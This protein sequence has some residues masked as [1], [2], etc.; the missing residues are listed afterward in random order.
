MGISSAT[1]GRMAPDGRRLLKDQVGELRRRSVPS[2]P[3][4]EARM[5]IGCRCHFLPIV[6]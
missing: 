6:V 3:F 2:W 4:R 5:T 1:G